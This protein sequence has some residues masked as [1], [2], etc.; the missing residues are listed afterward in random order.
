MKNQLYNWSSLA[1]MLLF[2]LLFISSCSDDDATEPVT[3]SFDAAEYSLSE[4]S[5]EPL[6]IPVKI[7]RALTEAA[8]VQINVS[9][10]AIEGTDYEA[11]T[12]KS[13][14]FAAGSTEA[15]VT[16][17]AKNN[18]LVE[19]AARTIVLTLEVDPSVTIV[20]SSEL[21]QNTVTLTNDD[22]EGSVI[23]EFETDTF[24]SNEYLKETITAKFNLTTALDA[25]IMFAV[26]Y[27]GTA[28]AG[29]HYESDRPTTL[30]IPKGSTSAEISIPVLN[31]NSYDQSKD[32]TI[33]ITPP[34]NSVVTLGTKAT[35]TVQIINPK[36]NV[37]L[38][39]KDPL[40][41]TVYAYNTFG[42]IAVPATGRQNND[43]AVGTIFGES[44]GNVYYEYALD[45]T[46]DPNAFGYRSTLW[47]DTEADYTRSTNAFNFHRFYSD[48][49]LPNTKAEGISSASAGVFILNAIR[50]IPSAVGSKT[51]K[52]VVP[53]QAV[54]V[55]RPDA[56]ADGIKNPTFFDISI[57]GEGTYN[58]DTGI[59]S[60]KVMF[61][62]SSVNN[63]TQIRRFEIPTARRP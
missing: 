45:N 23:A 60:L 26:T 33:A 41:L 39:I 62:E 37:R 9:G 61:D 29:T 28:V 11:I 1:A 43:A 46:K 19:S 44:F 56:T 21:T 38:W 54:R 35:A 4:S 31:T 8:T 63:G 59:I 17:T 3:V 32:L 48:G 34:D 13:V 27:G 12:P 2:S 58:E 24:V 55:Y 40:T 18:N 16:I 53:S 52:V 20:L 6:T 15:L 25:D 14:T 51:G 50:L 10:T 22:Q 42:D 5:V 49:A 30:N 57:S 7:S 36:A 47:K